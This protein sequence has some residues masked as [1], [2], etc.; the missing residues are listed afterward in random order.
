MHPRRAFTLVELMVLIGIVM[1]LISIFL[2]A[3]LRLRENDHRARCALNLKQLRDALSTYAAANGHMLPRVIY[4]EAN[5]PNG[6]TAFTGADDENPFAP[7]SHVRPNDVSASLWLLVR[8][9]L[10]DASVFICPSAGDSADLMTDPNGRF[11]KASQRGNFRHARNL[12]YSYASPFSNA[13]GYRMDDTRK[14]DFAIM[15]DKS[16][17]VGADNSNAPGSSDDSIIGPAWDATVLQRSRANSRNHG[18]AGQNV[19]YADSSVSFERTV[20]CGVGRSLKDNR[21]G[22]NIYTALAKTPLISENRPAFEKG[23]WANNTGP[24]WEGDSYLVPTFDDGPNVKPVIT[25]TQP[26]KSATQSSTEPAMLPASNPASA[27]TTVP[28]N[29]S[30]TAPTTAL[31]ATTR[32]G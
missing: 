10:V 4:D 20:Y 13:P 9:D 6:Y 26:I 19:L 14:S 16:P 8:M 24:A 11:V 18:K 31:P 12:S 22:D 25:T 29:V 27:P 17:G 21:P 5:N 28:N 2:P 1:I 3:W 30:S 23:Y 7:G 15:A 32:G